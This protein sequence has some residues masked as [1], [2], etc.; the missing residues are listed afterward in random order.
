MTIR[1]QDIFPIENQT[2]YKI[3]FARWNQHVQPLEVFAR[4]RGEWHGWQEYWPGRN[5]FNRPKIFSLIQYFHEPDIWL[6]GGIYRVTARHADRYEVELTN[7][8]EAFIG[9]LKLFYGY[10]ARTTRPVLE[11]HYQNFEVQEVLREAYSGRLFPGFDNIDLSHDELRTVVR[12]NREDWRAALEN[13]KGIYLITDTHSGRR[14][15]GSAYGDQGIWS[16]WRAYIDTGHGGNVELRA[17]VR[18]EGMEYCREH[19]RFA[20]L[21]YRSERTPD[22]TII[23][24]ETFWKQ[25]LLTRGEQGYNRN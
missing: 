24:R 15:V 7:E 19:F 13:V 12:N 22:D 25:I 5:E 1:L 18:R 4:D 10:R 6:F 3:H 9:R 8:F 11:R 2:E 20:L 14:Y 17:L 16:R 21:E 23:A